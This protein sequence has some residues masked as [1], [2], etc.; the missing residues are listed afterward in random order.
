MQPLTSGVAGQSQ[1]SAGPPR[2]AHVLIV[3]DDRN[4]HDDYRRA[5]ER[6]ESERSARIDAFRSAVLG[7]GTR[8]PD[9]ADT[10]FELTHAYQGEAAL[11]VVQARMGLE[12]RF[13]VAF[14]DMRMPPGW[15]GIETVRAIR[16][17]DRDIL[18]VIC[19]AYSDFTWDE[20]LRGV[21]D[22]RGINLL[23]KPFDPVQVRRYASVLAH[24]WSLARRSARRS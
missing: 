13:S 20:V 11:E 2:R 24:K 23:R 21:G 10:M 3:D 4:I 5:L 8:R 12:Q 22:G 15:N 9:G 19:T 16:A 7:G 6:S 1:V 18:V 17:V 14:V